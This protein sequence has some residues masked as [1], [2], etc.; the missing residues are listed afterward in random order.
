MDRMRFVPS[1]WRIVFALVIALGMAAVLAGCDV[2]S[3]A[4]VV[5]NDGD[6]ATL[7]SPESV[8]T[9]TPGGTLVIQTRSLV[10]FDPIFVAD[11]SSF[12]VVS[13]VFSLLFR[14]QGDELIP[15]LATDWRYE[16]D[17][18]LIF[19]L[20]PGVMWHDDNPVFPK[21]ASREV[22]AEDVVYSMR[23]A[24]ETEGATIAA[25]LLA[26]F[27]EVEAVDPYTVR[28]TLA[29]PN[30]LLFTLGRGLTGLAIVP[31]EAVEQLGED[32]AQHPIGS[33]PFKFVSYRPDESLVLAR[34]DLYWKRP[35]LDQVIY[36]VIP[37]ADAALIAFEMGEVDVLAEVPFAEF[38]RLAGDDRFVLYARNCPSMTQLTFN[39]N[40]PVHAEPTFRQAIASAVDGAA[41]NANAYGGMHIP[42]C[43]TA[44]PGVPG[45]DAD[46][47]RTFTYDPER[48]RSLLTELGWSDS[49][50]DGFL[51]R[52]GEPLDFTLAVWNMAPMPQ[53]GAALITQL[54]QAGI[55]AQLRTLEFGTWLEDWRSG[56][57]EAMLMGGFCGDGGTNS[58]W[59]RGGMA[60]LRGYADDELFSLL[61]QANAT[62]DPDQRDALLRQAAN[63]IYGQVWAVP[64][65][66]NERYQAARSWVHDYYG[67]IWFQNLCTEQNNVWVSK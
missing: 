59:G 47:C 65:G 21:G 57:D 11:D 66:F 15:D 43:G 14:R 8:T 24:V 17:R 10:Q 46:L 3:P 22:T 23:R 58:L 25:D 26:S 4:S 61:D 32:F 12:Q 18:H 20:R 67:T 42:G 7:A 62:V 52:A 16:D 45:Y 48:S 50:N 19:H 34:N 54:Q 5:T 41:I 31:H 64:L 13:N 44:G 51:D 2:D 1:S 33:G 29:S 63:R 55:P 28:L 40:N 37:D 35:L 49:D 30:A 27:A 39:L 38:D 6:A 9:P 56:A 53:I 36:R 60:S